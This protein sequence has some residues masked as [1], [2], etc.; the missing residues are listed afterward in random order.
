MKAY[1]FI[2]L[3]LIHSEPE[4]SNNK[5]ITFG[6]VAVVIL[7]LIL[8]ACCFSLKLRKGLNDDNDSI[9][10]SEA[11]QTKS[12]M[13]H[14]NSTAKKAN[15]QTYQQAH[16]SARGGKLHHSSQ[17]SSYDINDHI[18]D[19]K[20]LINELKSGFSDPSKQ[21][22]YSLFKTSV[23]N[24]AERI[25]S[26]NEKEFQALYSDKFKTSQSG[27][28]TNNT[29]Y[30]N[31]QLKLKKSS[32][33]SFTKPLVNDSSKEIVLKESSPLYEHT[34]T[35]TES[36]NNST[37]G[38]LTTVTNQ[39]SSLVTFGNK[40]SRGKFA[41][42]QQSNLSGSTSMSSTTA[43]STSPATS[44]TNN[45]SE[46]SSI[47]SPVNTP[48]D[49]SYSSLHRPKLSTFSSDTNS[50][51][52]SPYHQNNNIETYTNSF[53]IPVNTH[54][55]QLKPTDTTTHGRSNTAPRPRFV[56]KK[57][58]NSSRP[59]LPPNTNPFQKHSLPLPYHS[60]IRTA[61]STFTSDVMETK[62]LNKLCED[63]EVS[64]NVDCECADDY[65][66]NDFSGD[67][68]FD[69][70]QIKT[71]LSVAINKTQYTQRSQQGA[72]VAKLNSLQNMKKQQRNGIVVNKS[73][74]AGGSLS[75]NADGSGNNVQNK[76]KNQIGVLV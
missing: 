7:V 50:A 30:D 13:N 57:S 26:Y 12:N 66:S 27:I 73:S 68:S 24:K 75:S 44:S 49:P 60:S 42:Q 48:A 64:L 18:K 31:Q 22:K 59:P 17:D 29:A 14:L 39:S 41:K 6:V 47:D 62:F 54:H 67:Y 70:E 56:D 45:D 61:H 71:P 52:S 19:S 55:Q 58:D 76:N 51:N 37:A 21:K 40:N 10:E 28:L 63:I 36:N 69:N 11:Y 8:V 32:S 4:R 1:L 53:P 25:E 15:A 33:V 3:N 65:S 16:K 35:E 23:A 20:L 72:N 38:L 9:F 46:F 34:E 5:L 74:N 43:S 2:F